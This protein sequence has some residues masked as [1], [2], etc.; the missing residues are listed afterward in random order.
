MELISLM[1]FLLLPLLLVS[2]SPS[3]P[4]KPRLAGVEIRDPEYIC[5]VTHEEGAV[6]TLSNGDVFIEE[7]GRTC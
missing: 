5:S 1:R 2:C 4:P 6:F 3:A 7:T